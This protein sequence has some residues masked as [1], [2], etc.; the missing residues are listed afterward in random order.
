MKSNSLYIFNSFCDH[1][2][3]CKY[4]H[5][6]HMEVLYLYIILCHF[7]TLMLM[8]FARTYYFMIFS[9]ILLKFHDN[10]SL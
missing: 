3:L 8:D 9:Q 2:P 4:D 10:E 7:Y 1:C 6:I 5:I